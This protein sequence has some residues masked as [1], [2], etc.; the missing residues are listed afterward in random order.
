MV[1]FPGETEAAFDELCDFVAEQRFDR[2][3]VFAYS[4]EDGTGAA[5]MPRQ[6]SQA[7]KEERR[8]A[9]LELQGKES[10]E[11]NGAFVG[12]LLD[13][14]VDDGSRPAR[15]RSYRDA[16]EVDGQVIILGA[17]LAEGDMVRVRVTAATEHDLIGEVAEKS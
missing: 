4:R 6:L 8:A 16:P 15:G 14:L 12:K 2:L 11:K 9:L 17:E 13:V 3:G 1:G 10:L 5:R 7:V